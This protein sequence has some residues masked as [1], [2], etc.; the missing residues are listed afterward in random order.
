MKKVSVTASQAERLIAGGEPNK[1][2]FFSTYSKIAGR[3][4][5]IEKMSKGKKA[6]ADELLAD[7]VKGM[8]ALD[9]L[10]P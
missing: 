5:K 6:E 9:N 2:Q 10:L 3:I 8:K 7:V 1:K 4:K